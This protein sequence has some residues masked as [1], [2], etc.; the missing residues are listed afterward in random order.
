MILTT[1]LKSTYDGRIVAA[2]YP[3]RWAGVRLWRVSYRLSIVWITDRTSTTRRFHSAITFLLLSPSPRPSER[4]RSLSTRHRS[5]L[6]IIMPEADPTRP[7][8]RQLVIAVHQTATRWTTIIWN[9]RS[10]RRAALHS[11]VY[12]TTDG[13]VYCTERTTACIACIY[14]YICIYVYRRAEPTGCSDRPDNN[15]ARAIR[16]HSHTI[17][18]VN[19]RPSLCLDC[20]ATQTSV[21]AKAHK[22][23]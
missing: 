6:A 15:T 3:Y 2:M 19:Q 7:S 21:L 16:W 11:R 10:R 22:L 1:L 4:L 13:R 17:P 14:I 5:L 8:C 9:Y 20:S 23:E 12:S 18:N